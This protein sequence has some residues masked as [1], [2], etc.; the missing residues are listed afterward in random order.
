MT[1]T[2]VPAT[3]VAV[4]ELPEC[5]RRAKV[6]YQRGYRAVVSGLVPAERAGRGWL[7]AESDIPAL[8][9][10]AASLTVRHNKIR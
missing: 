3:N 8:A 2:L 1:Q 6:T 5:C 7:I 9:A 10:A 4:L